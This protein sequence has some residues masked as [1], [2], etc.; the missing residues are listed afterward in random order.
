MQLIAEYTYEE[1]I[2]LMTVGGCGV[3]VSVG[4]NA[5]ANIDFLLNEVYQVGICIKPFTS[6]LTGEKARAFWP[7][8]RP[9]HSPQQYSEYQQMKVDTQQN[10]TQHNVSVVM[11][12]AIYAECRKL[13]LYAECHYA[14]CVVPLLVI[15]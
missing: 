8:R 6:L 3:E 14:E 15:F 4:G 2:Y 10:D 7:L 12:I 13:A 11:L 1:Y 9:R 5:D